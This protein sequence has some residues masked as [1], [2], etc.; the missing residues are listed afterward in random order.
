MDLISSLIR[1][2]PISRF[3]STVIPAKT[4]LVCG[5]K[6]IP[7]LTL[8]CGVNLEISLPSIFTDPDFKFK[9]PNMAFMA[10]DLPAPFGP[11]IETISPL[12]TFTVQELIISGPL[13]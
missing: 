2:A 6:D 3:S 7:S 11:R 13:P 8:S 5:T 4:F 10:V 1:K 9:R 12:L